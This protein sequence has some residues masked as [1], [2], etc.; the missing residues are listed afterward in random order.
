MSKTIH[1][2]LDGDK[3]SVTVLLSTV[4]KGVTNK[5]APYLSIVLQDKSG[6]MDAKFWN[7]SESQLALYK[8]GMVAEVSG[9]VLSHNKQLQFRINSIHVLDRSTLDLSEFVQASP[10]PRAQLKEEI[11]EMVASIRNDV[12]RK[13]VEEILAEYETDFFAYP[14]ASKN[15]H[16]FVGGLATHVLGM[17]KLAEDV[18]AL[19]PMLHRDLLLGGVLL[20]DIGKL[21]EL[22]GPVITEYTMEGK[23]LGHISIMQAKVAQVADRLQLEGEEVILLRHMVLSHHGHYDYGSPVLPM[24]P[25]AEMLYFIDNMD[26]R[27]NSL[28]KAIDPIE[29]GEF[30][31]RIFSLENRSF[32]KSKLK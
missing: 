25:E 2:L 10:I 18:C 4:N 30:T 15:H 17:L 16:N 23:L 11:M 26:A 29:E 7:V 20:H 27:M 21:V 14:A 8:P 5:G 9:D 31:P 3:L 32:Y 22:S 19:Y 12:I 6:T 28:Q 24:L 13:I 1:E